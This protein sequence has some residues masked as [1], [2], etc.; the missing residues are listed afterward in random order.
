[1]LKH[2]KNVTVCWDMEV[3]INVM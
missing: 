2:H 1:V 3:K